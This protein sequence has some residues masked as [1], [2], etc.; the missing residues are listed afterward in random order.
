MF[1]VSTARV[2]AA[3]T[4][5]HMKSKKSVQFLGAIVGRQWVEGREDSS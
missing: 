2:E 5:E 4:M 1:T 3:T